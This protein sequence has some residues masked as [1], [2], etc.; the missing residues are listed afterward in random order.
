[1]G[2]L[3]LWTRFCNY[4]FIE[5]W[6]CIFKGHTYKFEPMAGDKPP[7]EFDCCARCGNDNPRIEQPSEGRE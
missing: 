6:I 4:F 3:S 5:A 2:K 7:F 1:M